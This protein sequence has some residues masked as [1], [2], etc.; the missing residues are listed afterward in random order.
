MCVPDVEVCFYQKSPWHIPSGGCPRGLPQPPPLSDATRSARCQTLPN[1]RD[2]HLIWWLADCEKNEIIQRDGWLT[3]SEGRIGMLLDMLLTL[4]YI[5]WCCIISLMS[6]I[7]ILAGLVPWNY[8][9]KIVH[10]RDVIFNLFV[11]YQHYLVSRN[12]IYQEILSFCSFQISNLLNLCIEHVDVLPI[13]S[14]GSH[15]L[16]RR[17]FAPLSIWLKVLN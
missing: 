5:C 7:C 13:F 14:V 4:L 1:A 16:I 2:F 11:F 15:I 3:A 6:V 12:W 8:F 10:K 17:I 9:L